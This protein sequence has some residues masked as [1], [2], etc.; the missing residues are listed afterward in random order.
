MQRGNSGAIL[1]TSSRA[2]MFQYVRAQPP[3]VGE[4]SERSVENRRTSGQQRYPWKER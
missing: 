4:P 1:R 2:C 3:T